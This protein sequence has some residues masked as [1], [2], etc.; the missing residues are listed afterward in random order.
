MATARFDASGSA[1]KGKVLIV[2]DQEAVRDLLKAILENDYQ[3]TEA[4]SGAALRV[5]LDADQ[6]D[7]VLLDLMLPDT[8]GL[9]LLSAIFDRWPGTQV[10]ILTGALADS[11]IMTR[12]AEAV[13]RGAFGL[14]AKSVDFDCQKLLAGV[15]SALHRRYQVRSDPELR[16][17]VSS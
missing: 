13:N 16:S 6:P 2:D 17:R 7:V 5:A 1:R 12:A 4:E 14:L 11:E 15:S 9:S 10:I 3:V 8:N